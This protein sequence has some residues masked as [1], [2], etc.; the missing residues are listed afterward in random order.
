[1]KKKNI[2]HAI[3]FFDFY[4]PVQAEAINLMFIF[5]IVEKGQHKN[6]V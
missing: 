4:L 1:M 5:A 6:F 3:K 2:V